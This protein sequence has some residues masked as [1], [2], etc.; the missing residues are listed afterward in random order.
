MKTREFPVD[1]LMECYE[2]VSRVPEGFHKS[3]ASN[4]DYDFVSDGKNIKTFICPLTQFNQLAEHR[5][6]AVSQ[7]TLHIS[8]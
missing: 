4:M 3:L 6:T 7:D 8:N 2:I 1:A 5:T